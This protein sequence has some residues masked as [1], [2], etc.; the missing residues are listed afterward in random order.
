MGRLEGK[1]AIV[2]GAGRGIGREI[3]RK[4]AGDGATVVVNDL[5]PVPLQ[6]T[7]D[8][9]VAAG[10]R[11]DPLA[12]DVAAPDFGERSAVL[13]F[14]TE[15]DGITINGIDMIHWDDQD[16]IVDFKVMVRPLKAINLLHAKMADT[17]ARQ[18]R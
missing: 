4:L 5:D 8:L 9:I 11:A 12:G 14:E 15:I 18:A 17:L 16:R 6:D 2:T 3:A 10:G 7:V 1:V 13:E